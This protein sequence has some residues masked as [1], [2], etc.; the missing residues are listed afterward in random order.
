MAFARNTRVAIIGGGPAGLTAAHYL[1]E[2]GFVDVTIFERSAE[3]GGKCCTA[4]NAQGLAYD[5]G[6]IELTSDYLNVLEI[7]AQL[8]L[9]M[10]SV[11]DPMGID[12]VT[13]VQYPFGKVMFS[14][15]SLPELLVAVPLY[16]EALEKYQPALGAPGFR[17]L[18]QEMCMPFA[19]WLDGNGMGA[20]KNGL[21]MPLTCYGYG[22]LSRIPAPYALKYIDFRNFTVAL[23]NAAIDGLDHL[24]PPKWRIDP[25][26]PKRLTLGFGH[27]AAE[28][29]RTLESAGVK[30]RTGTLVSRIEREAG[31]RIT[32]SRGSGEP[33][34]EDFDVL[35]VAVPQLLP[36]L[37]AMLRLSIDE[38]DLFKHVVVNHY[39][40]T[41][42]RIDGLPYELLLEVMSGGNVVDPRDRYP[43]QI[44]RAWTNSD[45]CVA[46]TAASDPI[47]ADEVERNLTDNIRQMGMNLTEIIETR[48]W[49]YFPH[50]GPDALAAGFY[51]RLDNLQ[52]ESHTYWAGGL[53]NFEL[54]EN[55]TAWSRSIVERFFK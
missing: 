16:Y 20:L 41:R 31:V 37:S 7:V 27:F 32:S 22:A 50:V 1:Q 29:A 30:I 28:L 17:N 42:C 15:V 21:L 3:V 4:V 13:R 52:G 35:I 25:E 40:T 43:A 44:L 33:V 18:P 5:M 51:D 54:V 49:D 34:T 6:A 55:T 19:T 39:A 12:P 36:S 10:T 14:G 23:E 26:W 47:T 53:M 48:V 38:T 46:Y 2:E 24:L 8:G 45:I 11:A 9:S